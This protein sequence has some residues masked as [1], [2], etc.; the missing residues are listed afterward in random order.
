MLKGI[1]NFLELVNENW[2]TI[3]VIIGLCFTIAKKVMEFVGHTNEER[4]MIAKQQIKE[5][6]LKMILD[7]ELDFDDWNKAGAIK[8]SQVISQ[9]YEMYPILSKVID[10][11]ELVKWLDMEI[12]TSLQTLEDIIDVNKDEG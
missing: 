6:I 7:A 12:N 2:T 3:A 8:R 10:Q 1:Q 5:T 11:N 4:I 9:I